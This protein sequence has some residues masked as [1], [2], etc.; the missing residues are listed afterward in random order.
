MKISGSI[1]PPNYL[2]PDMYYVNHNCCATLQ[3]AEEV[4]FMY[5]AAGVAVEILTEEQYWDSLERVTQ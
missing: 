5:L 3:D 2:E 1:Q 4:Q